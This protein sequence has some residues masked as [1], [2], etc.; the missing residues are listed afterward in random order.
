[1]MAG[2][3]EPDR[4]AGARVL[5]VDDERELADLGGA[6]LAG[7]GYEVRVAYDAAQALRILA[8]DGSIGALFS[9]VMMPAM[10]GLQLA[11]TVRDRYPHVRIVL[12]SG[13]TPTDLRVACDDFQGFIAKPYRIDAVAAMLRGDWR[14]APA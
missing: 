6:L 1:M 5:V 12:T 3:I 8:E 4:K 13:Y 2:L 10:T 9:D 11:Q 14:Q 7:H